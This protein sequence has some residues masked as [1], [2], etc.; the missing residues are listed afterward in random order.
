M[1]NANGEREL[2]YVVRVEEIRPLEG[3]DR[4]EYARI[5]AGWWI[6]V[7]KDQFKPGDLAIYF[8]IDSRVP[9][10]EPFMFLEPKK[11]KI[12]TQKMCRVISQ[13]L[14]MSADDFG[15]VVDDADGTIII[16]PEKFGSS[17]VLNEGDFL[18]KR[19][20]VTYADDE[21]NV[22]KAPSSDSY[23]SMQD[24]HKKV[25]KTKFGKWM[26]KREWGRKVMFFFFGKKKE[27]KTDWPSWVKKTDEERIQNMPWLFPNCETEWIAT[28]KIDG[29]STT[30]TMR[31]DKKKKLIV[32]SRNVVYNAPEKEERN[33]YKD[34][35]GNVYLEMAKKYNMQKVLEDMILLYGSTLKTSVPYQ[36]GWGKLEYITI[37]GETYGGNI[38]KRNYCPD[39]RLAVFNVIF[40]YENF[41]FRLNPVAGKSMVEQ[42]GLEYVP[43][44]EVGVHLPATCDDVIAMAHGDSAI[45]G[46]LREGLVFRSLDGEQSFK[47]VDP[48]FLLKY[49]S[50]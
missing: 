14:L 17:T 49:H 39:H 44:V 8:E 40:G 46:N 15:W 30:F 7:R 29:T 6:V 27:K 38:Q 4:V 37:Q 32:C 11:F 34:T 20:K 43:V 47:A 48:E 26:M 1:L 18:T 22:R 13:G 2:V 45:D 10:E 19:L 28:E 9:A 5:G 36:K 31:N 41:K 35:E 3:Y 42:Y 12:K 23:R 16:P 21:D 50:N 24:R 33:F 25:F